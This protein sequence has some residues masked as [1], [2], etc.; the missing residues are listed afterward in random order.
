MQ[1]NSVQ[2]SLETDV[3]VHFGCVNADDLKGM[4]KEIKLTS[5]KRTVEKSKQIA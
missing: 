1:L 2:F 5:E 4:G 3:K